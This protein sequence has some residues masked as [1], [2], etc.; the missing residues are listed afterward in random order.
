MATKTSSGP[1]RWTYAVA[2]I[3]GA[4]GLIWTIVSTFLPKSEPQRPTPS[5]SVSGT[6][7]V[8]VG[9]MSG[10]EISVGA[11]PPSAASTPS[12]PSETK[13]DSGAK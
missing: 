12:T 13:P 2:A 11:P 3:V 6:G 9:T 4:A 5:V 7:S 8:G 10:G 1:P